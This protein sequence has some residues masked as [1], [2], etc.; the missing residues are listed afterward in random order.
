MAGYA[1]RGFKGN[2]YS[3]DGVDIP[4]IPSAGAKI[5]AEGGKSELSTRGY[6]LVNCNRRILSVNGGHHGYVPDSAKVLRHRVV[7]DHRDGLFLACRRSS[8][9]NVAQVGWMIFM[10]IIVPVRMFTGCS[11]CASVSSEPR[12]RVRVAVAVAVAVV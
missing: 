6:V 5:R 1:Q 10:Y 8:T 11:S 2:L 7:L 12:L 3:M 9:L 4:Y